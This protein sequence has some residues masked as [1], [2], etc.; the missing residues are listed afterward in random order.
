MFRFLRNASNRALGR[1]AVHGGRRGPGIGG[2]RDAESRSGK[3]AEAEVAYR[4]DAE[5]LRE[6]V[7]DPIVT[8][9]G[10]AE[11]ALVVPDGALHM[12]NFAALPQ[13]GG[14]VADS[15]LA[16]HFLLAERDLAR[17]RDLD[18]GNVG[19][20][21]VGAPE[22]DAAPKAQAM[23]GHTAERSAADGTE[24][25]RAVD[26]R[27]PD[28]PALRFEPIPASKDEVAR[29]AR[30]V[31]N[32][33]G[34]ATTLLGVESDE[35]TVKA[36][37]RGKRGLH[38]ATH[39]YFLDPECVDGRPR[40]EPLSSHGEWASSRVPVRRSLSPLLF[41]G[42]ALAGANRADERSEGHGGEDGML[43]AA[44]IA[45]LDLRGL[46]WVVLSGC[47]TG[48]GELQPQEGVMG[49]E[50]AFTVAG[51]ST[52]VTSLWKVRDEF[53]A[54]WMEQFYRARLEDGATV[55]R[56]VWEAQRGMLSWLRS[57]GRSTHPFYW[58]AFVSS[59]D[60]R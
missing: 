54:R 27:C 28:D 16:I 48:L 52:V 7:W 30:L 34:T 59:G 51:A 13:G 50:R 12:I 19:V 22:F 11:I 3:L 9:S 53:T 57:T 32:G 25:L 36:A 43:M 6:I 45:S 49:L 33:G 8:R 5:T 17:E 56:A 37:V 14:Y 23:T 10:E 21:A 40:R 42:L 44:E 15:A 55:P 31:R 41:S 29:I 58:G 4:D 46:E 26:A 24:P 20:L 39:T 2:S 38:L 18:A 35:A 1:Q 60:W 47:E